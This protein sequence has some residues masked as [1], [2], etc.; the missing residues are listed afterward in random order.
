MTPWAE[1]IR[2]T[3]SLIGWGTT[4]F[5]SMAFFLE[6]IHVAHFQHNLS[7]CYTFR[8][9]NVFSSLQRPNIVNPLSKFRRLSFSIS[10]LHALL[11]LYQ[12]HNNT[13]LIIIFIIATII[14]LYHHHL[15][16]Q[17]YSYFRS[18]RGN[19]WFFPQE[20]YL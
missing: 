19:M 9:I 4:S 3:F 14:S 17:N 10:S 2:G 8:I 6:Q 11:I 1:K 5:A 7:M 16:Q 12:Q 20:G 13:I 15:S 18:I